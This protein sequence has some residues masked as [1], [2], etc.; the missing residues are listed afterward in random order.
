MLA[1]KQV[2]DLITSARVVVAFG[3]AWLGW[4]YGENA[5]ALA[6]GLMLF[7]WTGDMLDGPIA[8]LSR[9]RRHTWIGDHDLEVDMLVSA[10]LL[11]YLVLAHLTPAW[12]AGL[13]V[14]AWA[15]LFWRSGL[16]RSLGMLFQAPIYG[17]FLWIALRDAPTAG[18]WMVVWLGAAILLTWPR[19]PR[20]VVPGFL[21]GMQ[22]ALR[23]WRGRRV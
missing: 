13:Y 23:R 20:E 8:R 14:L 22:H 3:L 19:F 15:A 12:L 9:S 4:A 21:A 7:D 16:L 18:V 6:V 1:A 2:A 5:L 10:G 17:G 11:A